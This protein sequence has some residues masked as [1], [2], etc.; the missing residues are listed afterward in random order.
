MPLALYALTAGAFGIGVT[1]FVI[2][3]LLLDVSADLGVSISAAGL[4]ISGYALGVVVGAPLLGALTGRLPRKTLLLALM[5]VFTV[6]NLACALAPGY[7]TLMAARVLT[8]FAHAS[9]FGVGSVVATSLV[10][11]NRKASA[12]ALMFTGLTVANILGVPFGTWLGQAYGWRSSFLAV[13]L[14]GVVAFAVIALLVP[15]DEPGGGNEDESSEGTLAVLGRRSVLLGLLT[16]VLS[17]VGVFAA[18]TYLAP[19]LT[20]ISGFSEAAVS[21]ILLVFGGGLVAGNLLGGRLADRHLM[22][23]VIGTLVALS[24]VLFVMTAAMHQPI[25]AIIAVGL[26]GAAALATVAPL[27]MWVLEKARGAGQGLA[28]SFNIAAFNLGNAIGA[29]LGGFVIDHGPGL[30]AVTLVAALVPLAALAVVLLAL[31][32][33]RDR[34]LGEPAPAQC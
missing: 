14:V 1:E 15:R 19:I 11:P 12:I 21:P 29:W 8:A 28:S 32:F 13:T 24:A 17:W 26:L 5:V 10:A 20:R 3:G 34:A 31:R 22:P 4:L 33:E 23:T 9:F 27:Q 25:A 2:M 18:F 7:W 6:G 16:T 30:G